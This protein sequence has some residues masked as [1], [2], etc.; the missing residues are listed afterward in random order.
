M[1]DHYVLNRREH[2]YMY[3]NR[4]AA[5]V[6]IVLIQNV[7]VI[8]LL[9]RSNRSSIRENPPTTFLFLLIFNC[10]RTDT[11]KPKSPKTSQNQET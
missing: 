7:T 9:N 8:C 2:F 1:T 5:I 11:P 3:T 10:Q 4:I 6:S